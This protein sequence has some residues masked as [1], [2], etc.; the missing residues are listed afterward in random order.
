MFEKRY[1]NR[2]NL[3]A[4]GL[5]LLAIKLPLSKI[6]AEPSASAVVDLKIDF[7]EGYTME[8]YEFDVPVW[9]NNEKVREYIRSFVSTG[10]L[11][12]YKKVGVERG[13]NYRFVFKTP[14]DL[15]SFVLGVRNQQLV[16]FERRSSRG[17]TTKMFVSGTE[18]KC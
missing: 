4:Y 9:A 16:D 1:L 12:E 15:K 3:M 8:N 11:V 17:L 5:G 18:I 10:Q 6:A 13:V 7:P 2:R 14:E